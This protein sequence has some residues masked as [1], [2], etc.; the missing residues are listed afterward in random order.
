MVPVELTLAFNSSW[1]ITRNDEDLVI[2]GK[3]SNIA[4]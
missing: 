3:I 4:I 1:E 2:L